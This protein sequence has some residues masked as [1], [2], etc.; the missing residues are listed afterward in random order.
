MIWM[1]IIQFH[2][3]IKYY[4]EQDCTLQPV[5]YQKPGECARV[6]NTSIPQPESIEAS[7]K[8]HSLN[9]SSPLSHND[10]MVNAIRYI[11]IDSKYAVPL[12]SLDHDNPL[13]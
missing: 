9:Q 8:Q 6:P 7:A 12:S 10:T 2:V 11:R 5:T 1:L 3:V 13:G 4:G